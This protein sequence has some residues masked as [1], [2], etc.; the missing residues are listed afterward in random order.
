MTI[1]LMI[2][3]IAIKTTFNK[4]TLGI[5]IKKAVYVMPVNAE[6]YYANIMLVS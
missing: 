5:A 1:S 2:L 3:S 4:L 6:C